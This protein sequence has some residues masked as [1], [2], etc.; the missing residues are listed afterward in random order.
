VKFDCYS[1]TFPVR[2]ELLVQGISGAFPRACIRVERG[3]SQLRYEKADFL[4][5]GLDELVCGV[6]H[7]GSNGPPHVRVQGFYSPDV[8][9][10]LR[11]L[12]PDHSVS[13][14]DVALD[15]DSPGT[16][17]TLARV[18]DRV[19]REYGLKWQT[20]GDFRE[21]RDQLSGR[22]IYVGSRQSPVFIRLYEKGKKALSELRVGDPSPSLDWCRLELEIK[23]KRR[24]I[25]SAA[26]KWQPQQF[27]GLSKW[28]KKM[29]HSA[30]GVEVERI[31]M[32][33]RKETDAR[34][35]VK[36]MAVQ[37]RPAMEA[38]IIE[39]GGDEAFM[40]LIRSIWYDIDNVRSAA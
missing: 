40:R 13:R 19:A 28:S 17:D 29:L 36:H 32:T 25:K 26:S 6:H 31:M 8:A 16:W 10:V 21:D 1:A 38:V 30:C 34:R 12:W 24:P 37:Y 15:F 20:V 3:K 5:D 22:T 18:C 14:A 2:P 39:E 7:G 23:P 27:W 33:A 11:G 35:A 4:F 9:T